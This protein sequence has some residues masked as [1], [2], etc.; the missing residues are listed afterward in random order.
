MNKQFSS[1]LSR[2]IMIILVLS[3]SNYRSWLNH[4][5]SRPASPS[6]ASADINL[7]INSKFCLYKSNTY[8]SRNGLS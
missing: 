4:T 1:L 3:E 6:D 5:P 7:N 8:V 2:V